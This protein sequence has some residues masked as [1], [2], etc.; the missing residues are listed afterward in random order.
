LPWDSS[1]SFGF[2]VVPDVNNTM[3]TSS[4]SANSTTGSAVRAAARKSSE[5]ITRSPTSR[6]MWR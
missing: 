6:T 1:T 5:S 2:E 3:A 4:A